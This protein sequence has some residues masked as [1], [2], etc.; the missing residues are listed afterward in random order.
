MDG[1]REERLARACFLD[2]HVATN[3]G[4]VYDTMPADSFPDFIT[5]P[6]EAVIHCQRDANAL[7]ASP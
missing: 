2:R 4:A 5:E 6:V 7:H 3:R 1:G